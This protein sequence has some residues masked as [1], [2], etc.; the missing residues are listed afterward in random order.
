MRAKNLLA[1]GQVLRGGLG[2][3]LA[4]TLTAAPAWGVLGQQVQ[5][6]LVDRARLGGRLQQIR[7]AGYT[8][9]E[10]QTGAAG[11]GMVIREYVSP[12]GTVFGVSWRGPRVPDLQALLGSYFAAFQKAAAQPR[13]VRGPLHIQAGDLVVENAGHMRAF[14][15]RAY[16]TTL[17]PRNLSAAVVR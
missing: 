2:L 9:Q 11:R 14:Y 10:I 6:V 7:A 4:L 15:G 13:R 17:I 3:A 16:V 8:V 5:S 1:R 12:A